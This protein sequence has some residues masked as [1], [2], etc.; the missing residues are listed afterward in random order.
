MIGQETG[1]SPKPWGLHCNGEINRKGENGMKIKSPKLKLKTSRSLLK[2]ADEFYS[3]YEEIRTIVENYKK[4]RD[5]PES[6]G[7]KKALEDMQKKKPL[8][9]KKLE[10]L[11]IELNKKKFKDATGNDLDLVERKAKTYGDLDSW[12]ILLRWNK[13]QYLED[14]QLRAT[15]YMADERREPQD[16][17]FLEE[18]GKI[19]ATPKKPHG[20][21]DMEAYESFLK[22]YNEK[23]SYQKILTAIRLDT[24]K[25]VSD[26]YL[27]DI[28]ISSR[29]RKSHS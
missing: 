8:L 18:V 14:E 13:Q 9:E 12:I 19:I 6:E 24:G 21:V 1:L 10:L 26:E 16:I 11:R 27:R 23:K 25:S 4:N 22:H 2:L 3:T 28:G 5:N 17:R 7:F 15:I 20:N 29:K